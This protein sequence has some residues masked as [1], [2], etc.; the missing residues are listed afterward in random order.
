[1]SEADYP[2]FLYHYTSL[3]TLALILENRT[4][5][6]N[7]LA[8]VDDMDEAETADMGCFGRFVN[9]SCWTSDKEESIPLWKMYTPDM[10]GVRI[11]LPPFPFKK[12]TYHKGEYLFSDSEDD[13][14]TYINVE[15]VFNDN[16]ALIA[17]NQPRLI[18]VEYNDDLSLLFPTIK[19]DSVTPDPIT[20][21]LMYSI[22]LS[23]LTVGEYKRTA[24]DFQKEWRY[25]M[26]CI[27][28]GMQEASS[29]TFKLQREIL[30]RLKDPSQKAPYERFFLDLDENAVQEM[31]VLFGPRMTDAEKILAKALLEKHGLAGRYS[32]SSLRI[33]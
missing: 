1:M 14:E 5:C 18:K 30:T 8:C 22:D 23:F 29:K 9:V 25:I 11:K 24:W 19:T 17:A 2:E 10:H 12:Y 20:G 33:R 3:E 13:V 21:Q 27:P 4:L 28:I 32:E 31:E 7:N 15:K 26:T 6:L 16:R